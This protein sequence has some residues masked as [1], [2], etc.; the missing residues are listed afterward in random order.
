MKPL[1]ID[2]GVAI[3]WFVPEIH[4]E[5]ALRVQHTDR[6]LHAPDFMI[7]EFI[8]VLGKKHRRGELTRAEADQMLD[9]FRIAPIQYHPWSTHLNIAHGIALDSGRSLYDCLYIA[10]AQLVNGAVITA[11]RKLFDALQGTPLAPFLCWVE[12]N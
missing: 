8:N 4:H 11:D 7:I 12:D 5:A 10:L 6:A 2:A 9:A 3:K 1:I